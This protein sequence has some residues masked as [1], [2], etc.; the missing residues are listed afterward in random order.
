MLEL[1][2]DLLEEDFFYSVNWSK[3]YHDQVCVVLEHCDLQLNC[4]VLSRILSL[5]AHT[6]VVIVRV[7]VLF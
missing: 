1:E 5:L 7:E 6:D 4:Q 3:F 2:S